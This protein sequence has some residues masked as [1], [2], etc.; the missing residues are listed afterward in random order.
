MTV[1]RA[2]EFATYVGVS[3][4]AYPCTYDGLHSSGVAGL[5][6]PLP[7]GDC[8]FT[9]IG[10]ECFKGYQLDFERLDQLRENRKTLGF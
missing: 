1:S 8:F 4:W 2:Y 5:A 9:P 3:D 10:D 7:N 6:T